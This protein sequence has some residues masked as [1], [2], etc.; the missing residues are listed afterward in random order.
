MGL[1]IVVGFVAML[2]V[3]MLVADLVALALAKVLR[4]SLRSKWLIFQAC[5]FSGA[6]I[7]G[8]WL[9]LR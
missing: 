3:A 5:T 4:L 8:A 2:F 7:L 9:G 1:C 6:V